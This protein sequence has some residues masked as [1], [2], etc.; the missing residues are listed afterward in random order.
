M[1]YTNEKKGQKN[2]G[3][4]LLVS[5]SPSKLIQTTHRKHNSSVES[6]E[7]ELFILLQHED[8]GEE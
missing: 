7:K 4:E 1:I 2:R 5:S 8:A 3:D 6:S